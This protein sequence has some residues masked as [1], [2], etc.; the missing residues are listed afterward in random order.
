M[1]I[2]VRWVIVV[3]VKIIA[4]ILYFSINL[5][6]KIYNTLLLTVFKVSI[7][8]RWKIN[9]RIF[10]RNKGVINICDDFI[11]NSSHQSN[12]IGGQDRSSIVVDVGAVLKIGNN[13]GIS[14]SAIYCRENIFIGNNVLIGGDC[15]IYDTDFHSIEYDKRLCLED[16]GRTKA[17]TIEDGVFIGAS[18]I[19]L[20]GTR[21]GKYSVI[22]AGSIAT[23]N[24]PSGEVWGGNP[25]RFIKKIS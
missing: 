3:P 22:G 16:Q 9:G 1:I 17:V 25:I 4:D 14:N 5:F 24:I 21:I 23:G 19:I 6:N 12:P 15:K 7:G 8:K 2:S 13:V 18:T 11:L 20:K 10:L